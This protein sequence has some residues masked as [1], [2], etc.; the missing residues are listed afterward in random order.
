MEDRRRLT[1]RQVQ[2]G[3][4]TSI[5]ASAIT[6][7]IITW[8][9]PY[10]GESAGYTI[11]TAIYAT[12]FFIC[13][14][15]FYPKRSAVFDPPDPHAASRKT[16]TIREMVNS[17]AHKPAD[18]C[19]GTDLHFFRYWKRNLQWRN[20]VLFQRGDRK[21]FHADD[22]ADLPEYICFSGQP[23]CAGSGEK[24]RKERISGCGHGTVCL[25]DAGNLGFWT[26]I[27]SG[28]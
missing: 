13:C 2:V 4:A 3:A 6:L 22:S 8:F 27:A 26:A 23:V 24:D 5:I 15:Y 17:I 12:G 16:A 1:T 25:L 11:T 20:C 14:T 10:F 9:A 21:F 19:A 28:L 18:D 7:P